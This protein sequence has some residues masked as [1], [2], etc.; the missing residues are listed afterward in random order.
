MFNS[1]AKLPDGNP[2]WRYFYHG[3]PISM[4]TLGN[5]TGLLSLIQITDSPP[6]SDII[7][8]LNGFPMYPT[9]EERHRFLEDP[10]RSLKLHLLNGHNLQPASLQNWLST[11]AGWKSIG[12]SIPRLGWTKLWNSATSNW[13]RLCKVMCMYIYIILYM[14][15][16]WFI[17]IYT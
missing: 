15:I 16:L 4:G 2:K 11:A 1:Y 10:Y 5:V 14:Y 8:F 13:F 6:K 12:I 9:N 17:Y 3:L 7:C